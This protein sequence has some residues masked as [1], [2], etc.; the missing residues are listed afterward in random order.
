VLVTGGAGYIGSHTARTLASRDTAVVIYDSLLTGHRQ[1]TGG[2]PLV[3]GDT[4]DTALLRDTLRRHKVSAV[5]H[6]AALMSVGESVRNPAGYYA[7]NV[8]GTLSV[9]DA[10]V[11][12]GVPHFIFSSTAA[13]YGE[14]IEAPIRETH[15]TRPVNAYGETKLAVERALP[16]FE[17]AYGVRSMVLRYFNAS[18]AHPEGDLGEDHRPEF[19]LIPLAIDAARG[20]MPLKLFGDDYPTADGTCLRDYVHV[21]DLADAHVLALEALEKGEASST[22]NLGNGRPYSVRQ[23]IEVVERVSGRRVQRSVAPRRQG[24]AAVLYASSDNAKQALGWRPRF[25]ALEDI[26]ETAW[27]WREAHP[28]GFEDGRLGD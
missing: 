14:P 6:F 26:V 11:A 5:M 23:V 13:V 10:M 3:V 19:H 28:Q 22:Y 20:G 1:A 4:R 25:E 17:Q 21:C 2:L 18:G 12:E 9:L 16:H 15:P 7:N 8:L 27:R 24:D